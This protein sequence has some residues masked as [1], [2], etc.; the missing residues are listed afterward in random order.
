MIMWSETPK[1]ADTTVEDGFMYGF[2][3]PRDFSG[4]STGVGYFQLGDFER[5]FQST[6][7]PVM[8]NGGL[9]AYWAVTRSG[10]MGW[11][12]KQFSR[13][14]SEAVGFTR[15]L[16]F[17]GQACFAPPALS[18]S[19]DQP[20][21]FGGSAAAEFVRLNFDMSEQVVIP[22]ASLIMA[23]AAVDGEDRAVYYVEMAGMLHQA[24]FD[25]LADVW[26]FTMDAFVEGE[27][28][29][30]LNSDLIIVAD[31]RGVVKAIQVAEIVATEPPSLFPS[32]V[33]S[34]APTGAPAAGGGTVPT[35]SPTI[36]FEPTSTNGTD[37]PSEGEGSTDSPEA[38]P[39][40]P[41]APPAGGGTVPTT[42]PIAPTAAPV[43]P[44]SAA[45]RP[46]VASALFGA[47]VCLFL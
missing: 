43:A 3:F 34:T 20:F 27:M 44:P 33:P 26:N 42:A 10:Y 1:P 37:F 16:D 5:D 22:T 45:T 7:P 18:S 40:A 4:N 15:N 30:T 13:A 11:T 47:I 17:P 9:S 24:D 41:V 8:T 36:T 25:T 35:V 46:L 2:Q 32:D 23:K 12:P 39:A 31:T 29:M 28:A 14:R 6:T 19:E 38:A 21:V